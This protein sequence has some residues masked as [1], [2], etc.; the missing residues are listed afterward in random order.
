MQALSEMQALTNNG[1]WDLVSLLTGTKAIG[2]CWVIA[3]KVN[4]DGFAARL[5]VRLVSKEYT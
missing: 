2:Y 1:T 5:K 3:L 4:L